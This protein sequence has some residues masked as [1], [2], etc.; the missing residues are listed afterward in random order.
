MNAVVG[1]IKQTGGKLRGSLIAK[2]DDGFSPVVTVSAMDGGNMVTIQDEKGT[3]SFPV[4]NGAGAVVC[5]KYGRPITANDSGNQSLG[6]LTLYGR[7][8]Q[9]T[10]P[11][12]SFQKALINI[13]SNEQTL[14]VSVN[15]ETVLSMEISE[16][17]PGIPMQAVCQKHNY[18]DKNGQKWFT[19]EIDFARGVYI[20][21]CF[22]MTFDGTENWRL[23]SNGHQYISAADI[24]LLK[25]FDTG[26]NAPDNGQCT[27]MLCSHFQ[28]VPRAP[29]NKP[30]IFADSTVGSNG[31]YI[32]F[33][34]DAYTNNLDGWKTWLA[35]QAA[36]GTPITMVL[37][38]KTPVE[39]KL[40]DEVLAQY[41]EMKTQY[42]STTIIN[43]FLADMAVTYVADTKLYI[44]N[45]FNELAAAIVNNT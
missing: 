7:T 8:E 32:R 15:D 45:K 6:G 35:E 5:T 4:F 13:G 31:N 44:D 41:K 12:P 16:G 36:S 21:R 24:P 19:D 33:K 30:S 10:N 20:Q 2:G 23:N 34:W 27:Y 14:S 3:H 29:S 42:G 22:K 11:S 18:T 39:T 25:N 26:S 43:N 28:T 37:G 9:L 1:T 38:G 17:L 40:P